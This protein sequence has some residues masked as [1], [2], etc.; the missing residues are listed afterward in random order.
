LEMES[1]VAAFCKEL[2]CKVGCIVISVGYRLA[3]EHQ[4]PTMWEDCYSAVKWLYESSA[5]DLTKLEKDP[6]I[7][8]CGEGSGALL[9]AAVCHMARDRGSPP[10]RYQLLI[11]PWLNLTTINLDKFETN[12]VLT[13][14][15][16]KWVISQVF[17]EH[18][19][20]DKQYV[21]PLLVSSLTNLPQTKII[22]AGHDPL[23][24]D[25]EEY[26]NELRKE[27]VNVSVTR[28]ENSLHGFVGNYADAQS[29]LEEAV[30]ECVVCLREAF[31]K[32]EPV[33]VNKNLVIDVPVL[34]ANPS[35]SQD[36][37]L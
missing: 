27:D 31:G 21:S 12:Q 32:G 11:T 35:S 17:K 25:A 20:R 18:S 10:I 15:L 23:R 36:E 30:Y 1:V 9:A 5:L 26:A 8:V 28:Y 2:C 6:K 24:F 14:E 19:D 7:A 13:K 22:T 33:G 34:P 4:Y 29:E 16:M 37:D 3:P